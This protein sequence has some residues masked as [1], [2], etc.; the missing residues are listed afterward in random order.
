[1]LRTPYARALSYA[2]VAGVVSAA[3]GVI[4]LFGSIILEGR[5]L[6]A[7]EDALFDLSIGAL[8][9]LVLGSLMLRHQSRGRRQYQQE[10]NEAKRKLDTAIS[11]MSQGLMMFD[12]SRR[13]AL[14]NRRYVE[15]YGVSPEVVQPGLSFRDL[16]I[17]RKQTGSFFGDVEEYCTL[18]A[19]AMDAG[20]TTT[21]IVETSGGRLVRIVNEPL[22]GGGWVATHEDVTERQRL[23]EA[24]ERS[25]KLIGE[26][27]HQ[28]NVAL[29]NMTHGLCMFDAEG[30]IVLPNICGGSRSSTCSSIAR[31]QAPFWATRK[32]SSPAS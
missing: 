12:S 22:E 15:L 18:M 9:F 19:D 28:L 1:M 11:H 4:W 10:V 5:E 24:H 6:S 29:N 16:L 8:V 2:A 14:C 21:L 32:N 26:Q 27:R 30:H 7:V 20:K 17:H 31:Q 13:L 23:L 3:L 25:E